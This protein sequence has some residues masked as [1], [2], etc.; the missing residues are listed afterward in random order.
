MRTIHCVML[1]ALCFASGAVGAELGSSPPRWMRTF[2]LTTTNETT[3]VPITFQV[4][5]NN[6][7]GVE[8]EAWGGGP[9]NYFVCPPSMY[10]FSRGSTTISP[11]L[12]NQV[13]S[14]SDATIAAI[15]YTNGYGTNIQLQITGGTNEVMRWTI[16]Y[17]T[18]LQ[19]NGPP[20]AP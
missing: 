19:T 11:V 1:A 13:V 16:N 4:P 7:F 10:A 2:Y 17:R 6:I 12:T 8:F 5:T 18:V 20:A 3:T 9:T 15:C 14:T